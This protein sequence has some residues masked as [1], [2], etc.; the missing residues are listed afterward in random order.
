LGLSGLRAF[1]RRHQRIALDTSIFIYQLE[2][3][4]RYLPLTEMIFAWVEGP[5]SR[6]VTSTITLT[7]LQVGPYRNSD[8]ERADEFYGLLSI[9][10]T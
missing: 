7:E 6:A 1:L 10:L 5:N 2:A 4:A 8:E 9:F 3:N